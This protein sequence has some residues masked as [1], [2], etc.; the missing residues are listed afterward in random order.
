M[1]AGKVV[2]REYDASAGVR[3]AAAEFSGGMMLDGE[4]CLCC[5]QSRLGC[6]LAD[7]VRRRAAVYTLGLGFH[8]SAVPRFTDRG[9]RFI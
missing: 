9:R 6:V 5:G 1:L 3:A 8:P 4:R 7:I 2:S